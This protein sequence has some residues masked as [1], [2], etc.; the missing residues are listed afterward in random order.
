VKINIDAMKRNAHE[1]SALMSAM[2]NEKRLLILCQL[3]D[4]ERSVTELA[5]MLGTRQSTVSQHLARL[6]RNEMVQTRREAQTQF[7]SLSGHK[8]QKL[9]ATLYEIYCAPEKSDR[10][11]PRANR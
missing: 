6:R 3:V 5:D 10:R 1:A 8:V 4:G 2:A 9:I 7:Y 11:R